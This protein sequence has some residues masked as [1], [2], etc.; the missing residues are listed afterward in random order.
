[1]SPFSPTGRR[2]YKGTVATGARATNTLAVNFFT[3]MV[4]FPTGA[5]KKDPPTLSIERLMEPARKAETA[6]RRPTSIALRQF[7]RPRRAYGHAPL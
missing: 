5:T 6:G 1:M 7:A 3:P 4:L 2:I